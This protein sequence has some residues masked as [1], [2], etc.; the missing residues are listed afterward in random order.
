[1]DKKLQAL[2]MAML[3]FFSGDPRR[4]QHWV[5]VHSFARYIG[6]QEKLDEHTLFVLEA[7]AMLH[8]CGIKPGEAKYGFDHAHGHVQEVEGPPEAEKLLRACGFAEADIERSCYL[9]AHHH[10]YNNIDGMD[11]QI[12]VEADFLVNFFENGTAKDAIAKGVE[13]IFRTESGIALAKAM[14]ALD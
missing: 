11:Y 9:V 4:C 12:L 3:E 10:T 13:H 1:M 8:D 7:T 2:Y 14:F 5:K 6:L